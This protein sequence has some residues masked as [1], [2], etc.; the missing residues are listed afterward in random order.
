MARATTACFC[1]GAVTSW[2]KVLSSV[3]VFVSWDRTWLRKGTTAETQ[4]L[5]S[6]EIN[7]L[8]RFRPFLPQLINPDNRSGNGQGGGHQTR[9]EV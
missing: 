2:F 4:T 7:L 6:N 8:P 3:N 5:C 1:N 9:N